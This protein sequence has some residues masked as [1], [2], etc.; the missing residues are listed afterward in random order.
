M[1]FTV[2]EQQAI[3]YAVKLI[4]SKANKKQKFNSSE[5]VKD[6]L[7]LSMAQLEQ[8][9]F[10][11]LFLNNQNRLLSDETMSIGTINQAPVFPREIAKKA[12]QLNAA[13]VILAH[14]HPSGESSPSS[15][16]KAITA[17]IQEALQLIDVRT[18]DHIIVGEN[19]YSFTE[20]GLL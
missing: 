16:D 18:L 11:V 14:N 7:F 17:L 4:K 1:K 5:S 19:T 6:Y 10:R 13:A 12:L 15:A 20:H 2:E 3:D 8:E 9:H